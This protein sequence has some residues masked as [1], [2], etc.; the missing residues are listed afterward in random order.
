LALIILTYVVI[1]DRSV[2]KIVLAV[3]GIISILALLKMFK[4]EGARL[5]GFRILFLSVSMLLLLAWQAGIFKRYV[6]D[7]VITYQSA[8]SFWYLLLQS[9]I[10]HWYISPI[11]GI[12]ILVISFVLM[13][14]LLKRKYALSQF[15]YLFFF[16]EFMAVLIYLTFFHVTPV[17]S[18]RIRYGVLLEYWYLP[19]AATAIWFVYKFLTEF[20]AR[21]CWVLMAGLLTALFINPPALNLIM[22]YEGGGPMAIT[23]NRHYILAPAYATLTGQMTED[24]VFIT[25]ILDNYNDI[26]GQKLR[27]AMLFNYSELGMLDKVKTYPRGWIAL[28]VIALPENHGLFFNDFEYMGRKIYYLGREGDVNLWRWEE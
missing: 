10:H 28:S 12:F 26:S 14:I 13:F 24:D 7:N 20:I 22:T 11:L 25:D 2:V 15:A 17:I 4:T 3:Y 23:G 21:E 18:E 6:R 9:K 1:D 16:L 5:P 19:V 27:Y 8:E